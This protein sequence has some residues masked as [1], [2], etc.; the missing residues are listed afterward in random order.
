V[1]E[2]ATTPS[3]TIIITGQ[4][5]RITISPVN[6]YDPNIISRAPWSA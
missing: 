1:H 4:R 5:K 6:S 3:T 2:T